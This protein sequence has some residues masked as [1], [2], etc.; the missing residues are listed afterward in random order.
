[1]ELRAELEQIKS[2]LND[3]KNAMANYRCPTSAELEMV[4]LKSGNNKA[5]SSNKS[6]KTKQ[7]S[8]KKTP[9]TDK[10]SS[11]VVKPIRSI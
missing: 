8:D 10:N 3:T 6:P 4:Q 5:S 2:M 11:S 1:M 9:E 7:N